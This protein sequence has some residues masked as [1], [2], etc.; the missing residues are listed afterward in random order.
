MEPSIVSRRDFGLA[1]VT[2]ATAATLPSVVVADDKTKAAPAEKVAPPPMPDEPREIP[3]HLYLLGAVLRHYPDKR[4]DEAAITGIMRD[5]V[6]DLAKGKVLSNFPL[7]N[8]DEP[9]YVFQAYRS[10]S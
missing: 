6:G 7:K 5:I 2:G 3:E 9:G 10:E 1:L 4:L 8:S